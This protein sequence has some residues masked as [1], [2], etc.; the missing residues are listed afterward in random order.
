MDRLASGQMSAQEALATA[1]EQIT[2]A[3]A[4]F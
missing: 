1:D 3:L 2:Q 4:T